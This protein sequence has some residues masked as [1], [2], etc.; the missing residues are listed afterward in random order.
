MFNVRHSGFSQRH[1]G[2]RHVGVRPDLT[3]DLSGLVMTM[4][5]KDAHRR[6]RGEELVYRLTNLAA[7]VA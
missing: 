6:P 2:I 5:H 7:A 1:P 3:D 4:L